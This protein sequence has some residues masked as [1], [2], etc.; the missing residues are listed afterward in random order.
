VALARLWRETG[1]DDEEKWRG[2]MLD[3]LRD[4]LHRIQLPWTRSAWR[5]GGG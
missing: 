5:H 3:C 2:L 1:L 4:S